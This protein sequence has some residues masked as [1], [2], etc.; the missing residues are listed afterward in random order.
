MDPISALAIAA[1]VIQFAD[2][3]MR[4]LA[5][6]CK[7]ARSRSRTSASN[8]LD[9]PESRAVPRS[10]EDAPLLGP[11]IIVD[12][13]PANVAELIAQLSAVTRVL[14]EASHRLDPATSG[15]SDNQF[16]A[17]RRRCDVLESELRRGL[18]PNVS[19]NAEDAMVAFGEQ[20]NRTMIQ[21]I[22]GE[23]DAVRALVMQ[24]VL[25]CIWE[26][27][28]ASR[29]RELRFSTQ[30]TEILDILRR[31]DREKTATA[32]WHPF[33]GLTMMLTSI[34]PADFSAQG[35]PNQSKSS[36]CS[37]AAFM[38]GRLPVAL[39]LM[40]KCFVDAD[41]SQ[42]PSTD[43]LYFYQQL[44]EV[45]WSRD[46]ALDPS[47]RNHEGVDLQHAVHQITQNLKFDNFRTR[48]AAITDTIMQTYAWI[49]SRNPAQ[50]PQVNPGSN[51]LKWCSF[52][53]WL[54]SPS[55]TT[56]W[57][58]GKPGSGKST[59]MKFVLKNPA[60]Q[61]HLQDWASGVPVII[62]NY[63]AWNA[64]TTPQKSFDGL[65]R[66]LLCQALEQA[67]KL[68]P[69]LAPRRWAM[70]KVI[71]QVPG[72]FP[73]WE[74]WEINES[75]N[76]LLAESAR[77][78]RLAIFIDGLDEFEVHPKEVVRLVDSITSACLPG[79]LLTAGESVRIKVCVASRPWIEFDDAYKEVP[80]L[81]MDLL[82][83]DDMRTFVMEGVR[84]CRA[85][86]EL[87]R[88]YPLETDR[89]LNDMAC[90]A[91]GVFVWLKVVTHAL[92]E[93]AT[94][95][96]GIF[97]LQG[98]L[99]ALPND[100]CALYDAIWARMSAQTRS[101]AAVLLQM[102]K[103]VSEY[104]SPSWA[105]IWLAEEYAWKPMGT[106]TDDKAYL[107]RLADLS[108]DSLEAAK[109]SL[110][111]KLTSR[112]RGLLELVD[113]N[114]LHA[115]YEHFPA[116][117]GIVAFHHRTASERAAQ[118]ATWE[119]ICSACSADFDPSLCIL[120]AYTLQL[121]SS[122]LAVTA[123]QLMWRDVSRALWSASLVRDDDHA[124]GDAGPKRSDAL[125]RA[126]DEF[127]LVCGERFKSLVR[128]QDLALVDPKA[129]HWSSAYIPFAVSRY[130]YTNGTI[131]VSLKNCKRNTFLGLVARFGIFPYVRDKICQDPTLAF[132]RSTPRTV[133]I[134]QA[135]IF[136]DSSFCSTLGTDE[137]LPSY[138][139]SSTA[140]LAECSALGEVLTADDAHHYAK[141]LQIT[142]FLLSVGVEQTH[143]YHDGDKVDLRTEIDERL[144]WDSG[145][146][147]PNGTMYYN[148]VAQLLGRRRSW[149][150][151]ANMWFQSRKS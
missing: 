88:I 36:P 125:V 17:I 56:Y 145:K 99:E 140:P 10:W 7:N 114:T 112:T 109:T 61:I 26:E 78:I 2:V 106:G 72:I 1:A 98:V 28:K 89:L 66:T 123:W 104:W 47:M 84:G 46:W 41:R 113:T 130:A 124:S 51:I 76:A 146:E 42:S 90:K 11:Q 6:A 14:H 94:D 133:G 139:M 105:L 73:P 62:T 129:A 16:I 20:W 50:E 4:L 137:T 132:Q 13:D 9:P 68:L 101:R 100:M 22:K 141:R 150:K 151:S 97:E 102:V 19:G 80:Q 15:L 71:G 148:R 92:V 96:A 149:L 27:S 127:N 91:N 45:L 82:T 64:G 128:E 18:P 74:P 110:R 144:S 54:E 121:R 75:F 70:V 69:A 55:Q 118:P 111:R 29:Q 83:A 116:E 37:V 53:D 34:E 142:Q 44:E 5:K 65:K 135:A 85:F 107:Q 12:D 81:A 32:A 48:G 59:L 31:L 30:L 86:D 87:R 8:Q 131:T 120:N 143:M 23:L 63:Y 40:S 39:Q 122:S 126:L 77:T 58:T 93:S 38:H 147:F 95:G 138:F 52:P 115:S 57:I 33:S 35:V 24:T 79:D 103:A 60:L 49:F 119:A 134:L 117:R 43:P 108:L 67:P 25:L 21:R 3:G 136:P